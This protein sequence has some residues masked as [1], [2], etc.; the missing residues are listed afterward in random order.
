M[1]LFICDLPIRLT[2]QRKSLCKFNLP[3]L[4]TPFSQ[5]LRALALTCDNLRSFWSRSNLHASR[6]GKFFTVWPPNPSQRS[7]VTSINRL[8][9]NEIQ[10]MS[11]LKWFFLR[12][13]CTCEETCES[14]W[15]PNASLYASS[16]CG[17]MRLLA[18]TC[19]SVWQELYSL[20]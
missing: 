15:P 16:T 5:G 11:A 2:T 6:Q 8:L 13:A 9:A 3:L 18:T 20:L 12:L 19:E 4:A 10:D 7:W 17:H 14:V 1:G